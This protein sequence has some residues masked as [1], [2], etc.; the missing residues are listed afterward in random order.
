MAESI[1][2]RFRDEL[3][4]NIPD[5][6]LNAF[7]DLD[8]QI[9]EV[10]QHKAKTSTDW[11]ELALFF[12]LKQISPQITHKIAKE[13]KSNPTVPNRGKGIYQEAKKKKWHVIRVA[14]KYLDETKLKE[15]ERYLGVSLKQSVRKKINSLLAPDERG[16]IKTIT[17]INEEFQLWEA[18]YFYLKTD[19]EIA[20]TYFGA[21]EEP[22][23][24]NV[25][26]SVPHLVRQTI[27]QHNVDPDQLTLP[28]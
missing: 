24:Q 22:T 18:L 8:P 10:I 4:C 3:G 12:K 5:I 17:D 15:L 6:H 25:S 20:S 13:L 27:T 2:E 14:E 9:I 1:G 23:L 19:E 11:E 26:T 28:L 16:E 7:A 21:D